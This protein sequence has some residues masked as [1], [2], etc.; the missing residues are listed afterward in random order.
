VDADIDPVGDADLL[1]DLGVPSR[2]L[3][4]L[5]ATEGMLPAD[6]TAELGQL[7]GFGDEIEDLREVS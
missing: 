6:I 5:C 7:I 3:L 4:A 1:A 2:Q